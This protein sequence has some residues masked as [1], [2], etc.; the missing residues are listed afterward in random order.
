M[1][2]PNTEAATEAVPLLKKVM[3][4][5]WQSLIYYCLLAIS[6]IGGALYVNLWLIGAV[7]STVGFVLFSLNLWKAKRKK[8]LQ[9]RLTS[10]GVRALRIPFL[11]M[12][13]GSCFVIYSEDISKFLIDQYYDFQ[14]NVAQKINEATL[15]DLGSVADQN[16]PLELKE[17]RFVSL[18]TVANRN[19]AVLDRLPF[20]NDPSQG[21]MVFLWGPAGKGKTPLL[22]QFTKKLIT[23]SSPFENV[24]YV[25]LGK[26]DFTDNISISGIIHKYH[27][28]VL[29]LGLDVKY[30]DL[31]LS[32]KKCLI[33]FD[34]F[35]E[36]DV[37]VRDKIWSASRAWVK[38]SKS[39]ILVASRPEAIFF[40]DIASR[41]GFRG[42]QMHYLSLQQIKDEHI[43]FFVKNSADYLGG[44]TEEELQQVLTFMEERP[45]L[46]GVYGELNHLQMF[47]RNV[48][49]GDPNA[50][51]KS[52]FEVLEE[53]ENQRVLRNT[54]SHEKLWNSRTKDERVLGIQ[55]LAYE[56]SRQDER[57]ISE[58][59]AA[60]HVGDAYKLSGFMTIEEHQGSP[61]IRFS[62]AIFQDYFTAKEVRRRITNGEQVS[63]NQ[64]LVT[65]LAKFPS[66]VIEMDTLVVD[67]FTSRPDFYRNPQLLSFLRTAV[68]NDSIF[69]SLTFQF[70]KR[71]LI[72]GILEQHE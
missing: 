13:A 14:F 44:F 45:Q 20:F 15:G 33:I 3:K 57:N 47:M 42:S 69:D 60:N 6:I 8:A 5:T 27:H 30:Y 70:S 28:D 21:K 51:Q 63:L 67:D 36:V 50:D 29:S 1:E 53:L 72:E 31:V 24:F 38:N 41:E 26:I 10:K 52:D 59:D 39:M 43:E 58:A 68:P 16:W 11:A 37:S 25:R 71:Q 65:S 32:Q 18:D 64:G 62:P 48:I 55:R 66:V 34:D 54:D 40:S 4:G 23:G 2:D 61:M 35:D 22:K 46:S 17:Q 7:V 56:M 9:L 49:K 19:Q 12:C